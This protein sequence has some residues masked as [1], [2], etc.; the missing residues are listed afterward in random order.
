MESNVL[1][2]NEGLVERVNALQAQVAKQEKMLALCLQVISE[3]GHFIPSIIEAFKYEMKKLDV[4]G[5]VKGNTDDE[6]SSDEYPIYANLKEDGSI[7]SKT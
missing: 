2:A 6:D 5:A 7:L 1:K 4:D 3:F